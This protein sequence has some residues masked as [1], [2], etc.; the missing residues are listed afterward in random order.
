M[1]G[2]VMDSEHKKFVPLSFKC[3]D[4]GPRLKILW[5]NNFPTIHMNDEEHTFH[6][7]E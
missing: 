1:I 2:F 7:V 4:F 5:G 6:R 3:F